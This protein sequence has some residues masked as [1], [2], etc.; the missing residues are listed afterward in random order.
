MFHERV[1]RDQKNLTKTALAF[2]GFIMHEY[3]T[4]GGVTFRASLSKAERYLGI[5][6]WNLV[7]ARELLVQRGHLIALRERSGVEG[8]RN[9]AGLFAFGRGPTGP[10]AGCMSA[11][12]TSTAERKEGVYQTHTDQKSNA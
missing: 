5:A 10:D 3:E 9:R 7:P 11:H 1:L 6:R 12:A 4:R 2:A 8:R